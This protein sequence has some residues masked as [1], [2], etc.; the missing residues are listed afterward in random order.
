MF[1]APELSDSASMRTLRLVI[2]TVPASVIQNMADDIPGAWSWMM[3]SLKDWIN[4]GPEKSDWMATGMSLL[5]S[6]F[7]PKDA[8]R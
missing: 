7:R 5:T 4:S 1:H 3:I 2:H 8:D 6:S